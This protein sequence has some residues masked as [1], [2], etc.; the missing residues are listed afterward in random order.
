[1]GL[2]QN[3]IEGAGVSTISMSVQPHI[4]AAVGAPRAVTLRY[5][6]GNQVGEA[7]KPIQQRTIL[8]WVL[9]AAADI[10]SPGT[11]LELPYRWRRFPVQEEPVYAGVSHGARHPQTDEIAAALDNLARLVQEYKSYLEERVA[12]E[13]ANP[14]GIEHVPPTLREAVARA[15]RLLQI[16]DGDAMDQLREIVNRITV[17]ELMVSGKFV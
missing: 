3:H 14:S 10:E 13:D 12:S 5:P 7:G 6:A 17:L 1:M 11:I 4:T 16:V 9:R 15:D 8:S 2:V